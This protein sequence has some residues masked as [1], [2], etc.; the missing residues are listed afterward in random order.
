M[1]VKKNYHT[2][3]NRCGHAYGSDE[4][5][6]LAA[7]NCGYTN[8]GITDH[9]FLPG[10]EQTGIR[11]NYSLLDD[12]LNS[13][14]ALKTKYRD[15][16]E[17]KIGFEAEYYDDFIDYYKDL[18]ES[19]KIDYLVLGQHCYYNKEENKLIFYNSIHHD[20]NMLQKYKNDLIK[21]MDSGL[22]SFV[23]HPDLYMSGYDCWDEHAIQVAHEICQAAVRNKLPLEINLAG[24]RHFRNKTHVPSGYPFDAFWEI[25]KLYPIEVTIG[26]DAHVPSEFAASQQLAF[27]LIENNKL[28][29]NADIKM[30]KERHSK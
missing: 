2:H 4:E 7:I 20:F 25:V 26:V 30:Y 17:I 18:L 13:I 24:A 28:K 19:G 10:V 29:Y 6:V 27:D 9:V 16:I 1:L 11:G 23:A 14:N 21:G 15:D 3:T 5:F 22:F 8:L 12:Y